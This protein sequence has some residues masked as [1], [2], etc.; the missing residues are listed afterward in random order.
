MV[1]A[2][3]VPHGSVP[4][5]RVQVGGSPRQS[6]A[7][8]ASSTDRPEIP[9]DRP[10]SYFGHVASSCSKAATLTLVRKSVHIRLKQCAVAH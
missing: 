5:R 10:K 3:D 4:A 1:Y 8:R 6:G 7:S 9:D 2:L